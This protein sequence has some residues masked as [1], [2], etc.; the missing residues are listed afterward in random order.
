MKHQF[1]IENHNFR[2]RPLFDEWL[3]VALSK[4]KGWVT[5]EIKRQKTQKQL[6]YYYTA[7]IPALREFL[8]EQGYSGSI[9]TVEN[10]DLMIKKAVGWVDTVMLG[11]K[12][13]DIP[14]LKRNSAVEEMSK[15]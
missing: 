11:D 14:K 2:N 5:I 7:V 1:Y 13:I 9:L 8:L 4:Q 15:L 12:A 10:L 3:N 6:G